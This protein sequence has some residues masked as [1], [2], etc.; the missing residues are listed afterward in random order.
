MHYY[1][2]NSGIY[3]VI[4]L[5]NKYKKIHDAKIE[6]YINDKL[7][8][9]NKIVGHFYKTRD[10]ID[11]NKRTAEIVL[12]DVQRQKNHV[13]LLDINGTLYVFENPFDEVA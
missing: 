2:Y 7:I 6:V 12:H 10:W 5:I 4:L 13:G 9:E 3:K 11:M 8:A 1:E